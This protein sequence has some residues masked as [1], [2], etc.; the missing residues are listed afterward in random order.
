MAEAG[1]DDLVD[2][3][4]IGPGEDG[5]RR[6]AAGAAAAGRIRR[7]RSLAGHDDIAIDVLA[8][9]VESGRSRGDVSVVG[10]DNTDL[11]AHR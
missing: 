7:R 11:A 3:S 10:Y 5:A 1:L 8:A 9:I 2:V 6:A 4:R